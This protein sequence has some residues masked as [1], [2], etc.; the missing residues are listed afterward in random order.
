MRILIYGLN[1][2]PELV[3]IGKFTGEMAH[4]L[5]RSEHEVRVVTTP[6]YYPEWRVRHDY[7]AWA[8]RREILDT[9]LVF[10]CPLWVPSRP[11][12]I[13]RIFHLLSFAIF[14][15]P[16]LLAQARWRPDIILTIAPAITSAP[17]AWFFARLFGS[18]AWLHIQDF[19]LDA[20]IK[21]QMVPGLKLLGRL[22]QW[23]EKILLDRFDRIS[24]ISSRMQEH[25]WSKGIAER[26]TRLLPNWVDC[27]VIFPENAPNPFRQQWGLGGDHVLILYSGSMGQKQGLELL[28]QAAHQLHDE[29]H[30]R[31]VL[32]GDG[33]ARS[34]LEEQ[35][36]G[37]SNVRFIP[38]QPAEMLNSL[39]NA[40][41]VH[42]LIQRADAADLVMPSKLHGMM[43]SGKA[44][45]ATT[46]PDT[47]LFKVVNQVGVIIPPQKLDALCN[48]ILHLASQPELRKTLGIKGRTYAL[49]NCD[50]EVILNRLMDELSSLSMRHNR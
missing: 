46:N 30:I 37:L 39:L 44:I 4:H 50:Q 34:A 3:G 42:V 23:F 5:A 10:R 47:E 19:E 9:M 27:Q 49:E 12:G 7:A 48:V 15:A 22:L 35:A 43:A 24:T 21:L 26:K 28:I 13:T 6:P 45:I 16:A 1:F 36:A 20:A 17:L 33:S 18:L 14:S 2:E 8:Y 40:A 31:F 11:S 29:H 41:D 38:L 25:L 32:C